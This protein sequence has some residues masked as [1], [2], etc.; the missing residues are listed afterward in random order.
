MTKYFNMTKS[1]KKENN[2]IDII[3][4]I[5]LSVLLTV[6]L[7]FIIGFTLWFFLFMIIIFI[8]TFL[9][10]K[11]ILLEY[12][13]LSKW[14]FWVIVSI[15]IVVFI[16]ISI[17]WFSKKQSSWSNNLDNNIN[18]INIC[19][20]IDLKE[21]I[22]PD[23]SIKIVDK[24]D[25]F[26]EVSKQSYSVSELP[27]LMYWYSIKETEDWFYTVLEFCRWDESIS[28][29]KLNKDMFDI[30]DPDLW[31]SIAWNYMNF[32]NI[33]NLNTL[34]PGQYT[35]YLYTSTNG[36]SWKITQK[37]NFNIN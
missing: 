17:V 27:N 1:R 34:Q 22:N 16:T 3:W 23:S 26:K 20:A 19:K 12:F 33:E 18:N 8:I 13:I 35:I 6:V 5:A 4:V 29:D 31:P 30:A 14:I 32:T 11:F 21:K 36:K 15:F 9:I 37:F 7:F 28:K 10:R 2:V 25:V 24:N